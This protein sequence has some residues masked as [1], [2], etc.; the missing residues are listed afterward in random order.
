MDALS[1]DSATLVGNSFGG[2]C[3][4]G[5]GRGARAGQRARARLGARARA[6]AVGGARGRWRAEEAALERGDIEAAVRAWLRDGRSRT[7]RS[8]FII[9]RRDAAARVGLAGRGRPVSQAP[10]PVDEHPGLLAGIAVRALVAVG[11]RVR[12]CATFGSAPRYWRGRCLT[13]TRPS[14]RSRD[15]SCRSRRRPAFSTWQSIPTTSGWGTERFKVRGE[16]LE[17]QELSRPVENW[18]TFAG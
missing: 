9:G 18:S 5:G 6:R 13:R 11:R 10:A 4:A 8:S 2:H 7:R 16:S 14:S 12:T 15:I 1:I 3:A 17:G